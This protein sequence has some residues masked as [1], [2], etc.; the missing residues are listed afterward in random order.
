MQKAPKMKRRRRD[1][2]VASAVAEAETDQCCGA[3]SGE[4]VSNYHRGEGA[5]RVPSVVPADGTLPLH[6]DG[7]E[8][9]GASEPA[10]GQK[11]PATSGHE[12]NLP[13]I[14]PRGASMP[15]KVQLH[16]AAV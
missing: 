3:D 10:T 12:R 5:D 4:S 7:K 6:D 11:L 8:D 14:L 2:S 9:D 1:G 15:I 13:Q 16:P